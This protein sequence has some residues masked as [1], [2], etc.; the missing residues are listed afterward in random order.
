MSATQ[1]P[2]HSPL[3][4]TAEGRFI[5]SGEDLVSTAETIS[6]N[7]AFEARTIA[8]AALSALEAS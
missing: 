8:L 7:V 2:E 1:T 3:P 6:F 5:V 4:W